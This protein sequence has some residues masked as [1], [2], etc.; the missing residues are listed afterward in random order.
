MTQRTKYKR[1]ALTGLLSNPGY[2]NSDP[3]ELAHIACKIADLMMEEDE[4]GMAVFEE[5]Q[6][7]EQA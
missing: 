5:E 3:E 4:K 7:E 1:S 2:V 6:E